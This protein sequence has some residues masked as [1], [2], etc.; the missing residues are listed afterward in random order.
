MTHVAFTDDAVTIPEVDTGV[1]AWRPLTD[2]QRS[3]WA[4]IDC[5]AVAA[6]MRPVGTVEEG[7]VF[8]CT[9]CYESRL[10]DRIESL[11]G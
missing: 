5:G 6:Q 4:C 9:S 2:E 7:Q 1:G 8:C 3:G 10:R 11:G